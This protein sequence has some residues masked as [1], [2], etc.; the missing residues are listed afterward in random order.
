MQ[1]G[2]FTFW[3][4]HGQLA[5]AL[6]EEPSSLAGTFTDTTE[7]NTPY[8]TGKVHFVFLFHLVAEAGTFTGG[9]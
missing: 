6:W 2:L 8:L 3:T 1:M 7:F 9:W 5:L 4:V